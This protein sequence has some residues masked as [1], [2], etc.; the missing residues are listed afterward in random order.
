VGQG[1]T[2]EVRLPLARAASPSPD[3]EDGAH[4]GNGV[5]HE[6][7]RVLI[8][9]DN[10]D[11]R[12]PLADLCQMWGH[13]VFVARDGDEGLSRAIEHRPDV[14]FVDIGLPG[15]NGYDLARAIRARPEVED[16]MLVAFTG[17]GAA[18]DRELAHEAGFDLHVVKP[19]DIPKLKTLLEE[20]RREA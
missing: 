18:R 2:F 10:A 5:G 4:R 1:S 14:A 13:E 19:I 17:Y 15:R 8:V 3:A 7:R 11:A 9:E 16:M 20:L 12:Q 6:T